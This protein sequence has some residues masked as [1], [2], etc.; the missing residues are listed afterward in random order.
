MNLQTFKP[1]TVLKRESNTCA[2]LWLSQNF[3]EHLFWRTTANGCFWI[4]K[5]CFLRKLFY[6]SFRLYS[7]KLYPCQR[8]AKGT[9]DETKIEATGYEIKAQNTQE[10]NHNYLNKFHVKLDRKQKTFFCSSV[11]K[12]QKISTSNICDG[13]YV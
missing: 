3:Y 11:S 5:K 1:A 10:G 4:C 13:A 7:C 6:F 2:F 12:F 9:F 8:L